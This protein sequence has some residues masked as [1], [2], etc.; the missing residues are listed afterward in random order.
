MFSLFLVC[1]F[2]MGLKIMKGPATEVLR[3]WSELVVIWPEICSPL[4]Q[5]LNC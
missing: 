1:L 5:K 3:P 4:P 2:L